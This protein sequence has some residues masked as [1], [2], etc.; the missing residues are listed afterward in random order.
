M[1]RAGG[2][3]IQG[4]GDSNRIQE[5]TGDRDRRQETRDKR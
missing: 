3:R 4:T 5:E 1:R 2:Y